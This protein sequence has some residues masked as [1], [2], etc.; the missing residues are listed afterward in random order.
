M[1]A[2]HDD[3]RLLFEV[4]DLCCPIFPEVKVVVPKFSKIVP[5]V[6]RAGHPLT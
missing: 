4:G 3:G 2:Q 5:G 6:S 1:H